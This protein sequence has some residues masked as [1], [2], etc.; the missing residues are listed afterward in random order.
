MAGDDVLSTRILERL[1]VV[2]LVGDEAALSGLVSAIQSLNH[3]VLTAHDQETAVAVAEDS[4]PDLVVI[5]D[6]A[7]GAKAYTLCRSLKSHERLTEPAILIVSS[8]AD[9]LVQVRAFESGANDVLIS[10]HNDVLMRARVRALLKYRNAVRELR[11]A[12]SQMEERVAYRTAELRKSTDELARQLSQRNTAESALR[13]TQEMLRQAQKVEA[14]GQLAGGVAHD[15]NNIVF[16]ILGY[17][18]LLE[19]ELN[20]NDPRFTHVVRIREAGERAAALTRQLLAFARRQMLQ[21]Q[22]LELNR[23]V[24]DLTVMLRRLIGEDLELVTKLGE[25]LWNVQVDR[26]Q[27]EQVA[28]NLTINARD[29]MPN[30]GTVTIETANE[31]VDDVFAQAHP[32]CKGGEY[33]RLSIS[34]TGC[35]MDAETET[36]LFEPFFT[37]KGPGRGTGLGLAVVYGIVKQSGGDI[38]VTTAPGQG[39]RFDIYLPRCLRAPGSDSDGRGAARSSRAVSPSSF[40]Y[41]LP[42]LNGGLVEVGDE[43]HAAMGQGETILLVEDEDRVRE[44]A[45]TF[46]VERNYKVLEAQNASEAIMLYER[47]RSAIRLLLTDVVMPKMS[48][49][50]LA[51]ILVRGNPAL[52]VLFMSGYTDRAVGVDGVENACTAF[53]RKPFTREVLLQTVR[54]ILDMVPAPETLNPKP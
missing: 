28:V 34:D 48:G 7:L 33:V 11:K 47:N 32:G 44:L 12:Y 20:R 26:V 8:S 23:V 49:R 21:P 22:V 5:S 29:A 3:T 53:L 54:G 14:L 17:C 43:A 46:L 35:G 25:G 6:D 2:L 38:V 51:G 52:R 24:A 27:M 40:L 41:N 30:G 15:F 42:E 18:E 13:K 10:P 19:A 31:V 50:E 37:T 36:H 45:R 1:S 9:P 39:A 16:V 4:Q